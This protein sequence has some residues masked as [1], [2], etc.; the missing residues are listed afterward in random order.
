MMMEL[1]V[2][3][4]AMQS[5]S[6]DLAQPRRPDLVQSR[7]ADFQAKF[8]SSIR[9]RSPRVATLHR[10]LRLLWDQSA[11]SEELNR[12]PFPKMQNARGVSVQGPSITRGRTAGT[13]V[14]SLGE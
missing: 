9:Q 6:P 7:L 12:L 1:C 8:D 4:Y 11:T 10:K 13:A 5:I 3:T 14:E 2:I